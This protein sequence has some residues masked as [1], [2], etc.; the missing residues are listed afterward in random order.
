MLC[1]MTTLKQVGDP[2]HPPYLYHSHFKQLGDFNHDLFLT[3]SIIFI[4]MKINE[5]KIKIT[6]PDVFLYRVRIY[7]MT[8]VSTLSS[9]AIFFHFFF[10]LKCLQSLFNCN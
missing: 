7:L 3:F 9:N 5:K 10:H 4:S 1:L 2:H 6:I 8:T